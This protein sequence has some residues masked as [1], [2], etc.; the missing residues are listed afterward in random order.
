LLS[1]LVLVAASSKPKIP[2][3][4]SFARFCFSHTSVIKYRMTCHAFLFRWKVE[5]NASHTAT[6]AERVVTY[7]KIDI[8]DGNE[9]SQVRV[10]H[11]SFP[12][13]NVFVRPDRSKMTQLT[14]SIENDGIVILFF[15][16]PTTFQDGQSS[17]TRSRRR[18]S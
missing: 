6:S 8:V 9:R 13:M 7:V 11:D 3:G 5:S 16:D 2:S 12:N 18:P 1:S 14:K 10:G 17:L 4:L 15:P